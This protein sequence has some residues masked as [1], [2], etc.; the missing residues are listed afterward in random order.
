MHKGLG[1]M[2]ALATDVG[3][4]KRVLTNVKA[5]GGF[6]ELR[7]GQLLGDMLTADQYEKQVAVRDAVTPPRPRP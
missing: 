3:G 7:L 5:R 6:G 1:E 4:L 2:Q